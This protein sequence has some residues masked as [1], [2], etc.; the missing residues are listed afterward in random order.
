[1]NGCCMGASCLFLLCVDYKLS[2]DCANYCCVVASYSLSVGIRHF[3]A[4]NN[5]YL[6]ISVHCY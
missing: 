2:V 4:E 3:I 6:Q 1:M 5:D